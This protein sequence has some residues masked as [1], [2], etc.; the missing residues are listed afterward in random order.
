MIPI[1]TPHSLLKFLELEHLFLYLFFH[2]LVPCMIR[3]C[4]CCGPCGH[5]FYLFWKLK[6]NS[7]CVPVPIF[8]TYFSASELISQRPVVHTYVG[9]W[10]TSF[11]DVVG[12]VRSLF[13]PVY[14]YIHV[15]YYILYIN[16]VPVSIHVYTHIIHIK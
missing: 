1:C 13:V 12:I 10:T 16:I 9:L 7:L 11:V 3:V 6:K 5:Y 8:A 2:L 4:V 14:M 15:M